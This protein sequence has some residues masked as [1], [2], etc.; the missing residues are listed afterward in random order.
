MYKQVKNLVKKI[1]PQEF[2]FRHEL[3]FKKVLIPIYSGKKYHC[4]ICKRSWKRFIILPDDDLLCPYCGSRS[5]TRRLYEVLKKENVFQGNVL[6]F[7]PS[8]SLFRI[9]KKNRNFK[10]YSTDFENEFLADFQLDITKI[11]MPDNTFDTIICYHILEHIEDD[12]K[13]MQELKRVLKPNG[14]CFIQTPFK[15]GAIYEDFSIKNPQKRLK[16][17]GQE[18]H[19]RIYSEEGLLKRLQNNGLQTYCLHF[20]ENKVPHGL[21][22]ESIIIAT[23]ESKSV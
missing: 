17:F 2:L 6:H 5:R 22:A 13:A 12:Q 23:P 19:V 21:L 1:V 3:L 18:D 8:R 7:S 4:S 15:N 16:A 11:D 10:Y 9:F 14:N 20:N